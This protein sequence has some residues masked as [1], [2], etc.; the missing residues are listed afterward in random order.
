MGVAETTGAEPS[1]LLADARA[2]DQAAFGALLA[3]HRRALH[4]HC[5]RMLGSID[6]AE[7]ALQET[8]LR[9]WRSLHTY[10]SRAPL[11]HWLYRIATTTCLKAIRGR[12]RQ[13]ATLAEVGHLQPYPDHLLDELDPATLAEQRE[14]V[15][16]AFIAALQLLP[17]TQRAVVLLREV[18]CWS[19]TEVAAFL[20]SSVPAV[21]SALQRGRATL[22]SRTSAH[23]RPL[24]DYERRLLARFVSSWQNC[25]IDGL[26]ALLREDAILRMPPEA[27]EFRGRTAIAE[28]FATVPAQGRLDR[29]RLRETA[30]NRQP[31]LAA[32]LPDETGRCRGYGLMVLT[33][34]PAG[35]AEITGFPDARLL[36]WF[37]LPPE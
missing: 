18:L 2:G 22:R 5:Y 6:E 26:A 14:S 23:E 34:T 28:F 35:V 37:S 21:N 24:I 30:A 8:L 36:G 13:P 10:Q 12:R 33:I 15:A 9:A 32:Y 19:A 25:D 7:E 3:P 1:A 20:D 4:L 27:V 31:A 16:L 17:A 29:I 11:H